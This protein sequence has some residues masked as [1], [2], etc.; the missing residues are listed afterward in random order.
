[1]PVL[2][3]GEEPA[4]L[5]RTALPPPLHLASTLLRYSPLGYRERLAA[6]RAATALQ[7]LDPDDPALDER[8]LRRLA[9]GARPVGERDHAA[10]GT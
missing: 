10:S 9:S 4:L 7:K 3:E 1:M 5:S 8:D 2:R 6:A